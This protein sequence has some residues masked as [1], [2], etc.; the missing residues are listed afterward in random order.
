MLRLVLAWRAFWKLWTV[1]SFNFLIF[2]GRGHPRI[3]NPRIRLYTCIYI[4][5]MITLITDVFI[6]Q[7]GWN[8]I[9]DTEKLSSHPSRIRSITCLQG[10]EDPKL[11]TLIERVFITSIIVGGVEG[12]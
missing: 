11:N 6:G 1:Y 8:R 5:K 9:H 3:L 7:L 2:S 12:L 10:S 4:F